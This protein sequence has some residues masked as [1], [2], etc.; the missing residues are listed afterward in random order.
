[1]LQENGLDHNIVNHT[2]PMGISLILIL[3]RNVF[4]KN[5]TDVIMVTAQ[6]GV[7]IMVCNL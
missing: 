6:C 7:A 2:Q 4:L 3:R 5:F 1:M